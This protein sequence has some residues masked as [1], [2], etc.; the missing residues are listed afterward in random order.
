MGRAQSISP[1]ALRELARTEPVV[2]IGV[3]MLAPGPLDP[4]LPGDQ[5]SASLLSLA[6]IVADLPRQQAIALHCG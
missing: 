2:V 5:R 3:G 6:S 1:D 4:R